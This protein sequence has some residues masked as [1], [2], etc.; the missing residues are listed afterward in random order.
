[1]KN[2][3]VQMGIFGDDRKMRPVVEHYVQTK[4]FDQPYVKWPKG[5]VKADCELNKEKW[6]SRFMPGWNADWTTSA[7][8]TS[9][10]A[11]NGPVCIMYAS[12]VVAA[13]T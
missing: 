2:V 5:F 8:E 1:M 11:L 7:V 10:D 3:A 13:Y 4:H 6:Q 12:V 9:S